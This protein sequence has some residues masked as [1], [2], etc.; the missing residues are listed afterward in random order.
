MSEKSLTLAIRLIG[1]SAKEEETFSAVLS[2][3]REKNYGYTVIK[4]GNLREPDVFIVNAE[5]IKALAEL[6]VLNPGSAQPVLLIGKTDVSFPY[7]V[8]PR[9]IRWRN[10]FDALDQLAEKRELILNTL[11]AFDTVAV[12]ERRRSARLD[13]DLTDPDEY[14]K[15]RGKKAAGKSILI[16]DKDP[17]FK[18]YVGAIM[19]RYQI[20]VF[21]S[22]QTDPALDLDSKQ[23][24]SLVMINTST[25]SVD[26]YGLCRSLK[27]QVKQRGK[28]VIFLVG[29]NF[30]Y[31]H[32][33]AQNVGCDGFLDKPVSRKQ[34]LLTIQRFLQIS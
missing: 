22:D 7:T 12:P 1:F 2:V 24:F 23:D 31:N 30:Q 29:K 11:S 3:V 13:L 20:P 15:M 4:A 34:L 25:P 27:A 6:S 33:F 9:P 28:D 17:R 21:V 5:D 8:L 16:I 26:P 19:E 32:D 14:K 10:M 18:E